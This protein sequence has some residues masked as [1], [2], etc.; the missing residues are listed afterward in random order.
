MWGRSASFTDKT[1]KYR[2]RTMTA[3]NWQ[4]GDA[5]TCTL[6]GTREPIDGYGLKAAYYVKSYRWYIASS[7]VDAHYQSIRLRGDV[8]DSPMCPLGQCP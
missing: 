1:T 4:R 7:V 6:G 8:D 5:D 3:L 2:L